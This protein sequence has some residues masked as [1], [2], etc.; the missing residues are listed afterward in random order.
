MVFDLYVER[1]PFISG[2]ETLEQAVSS[3]LHVC[4][5][6]NIHYPVGSG[7]LCTYLQRYAGKLD[8]HGTTATMKKRDQASKDDKAL[9]PLKKVFDEFRQKMYDIL[10]S[11]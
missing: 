1:E 3:F 8:E 11:L 10:S 7:F 6:A 9:R 5:V 4:F 2:L